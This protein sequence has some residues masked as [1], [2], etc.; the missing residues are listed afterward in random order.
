[1]KKITGILS[2]IMILAVLT[3]FG[4]IF[5]KKITAKA[6]PNETAVSF[7]T[8]NETDSSSSEAK[9]VTDTSTGTKALAAGVAIGLA[10]LGGAIGM[11]LAIFKSV[12]GISRQPEADGKIRTTLMLG[13]VF[14]ETVVIYALIVTILIVFVM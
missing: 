5:A 8:V 6:A 7:D 1:M 14:I 10:A 4:S 9:L 13:L 2:V 3:L 12:D 11:G